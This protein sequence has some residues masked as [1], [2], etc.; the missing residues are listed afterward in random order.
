MRP[1]PLL[2]LLLCGTVL[3]DSPIYRINPD[4]GRKELSHVI[5]P[6]GDIVE[7]DP[8]S[9]IKR[10]DKGGYRVEDDKVYHINPN[11]GRKELSHVIQPDG[12]IVEI[13]PKSGLERSDK[14]SLRIEGNDIYWVNPN[15]GRMDFKGSY[16]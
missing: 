14:G 10:S 13:D 2:L 11:T 9:G 12:D 1:F 8:R 16:E 6:D 5:E 15:T 4:T 3:A 7:I